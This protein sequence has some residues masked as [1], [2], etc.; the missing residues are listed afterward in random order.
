M[1]KRFPEAMPRRLPYGL[2]LACYHDIFFKKRPSGQTPFQKDQMSDLDK[3]TPGAPPKAPP[4]AEDEPIIDLVDEI[5]EPAPE[6]L[7]PL[8]QNLFGIT[9][10]VPSAEPPSSELAD[11]GELHFDEEEHQPIEAGLSLESLPGESDATSLKENLDWLF[12][13]GGSEEAPS[14][15]GDGPSDDASAAVLKE[16]AVGDPFPEAM[17]PDVAATEPLDEDEDI[18]LIEV[19]DDDTDTEIVW[20][21]DLDLDKAPAAAESTPEAPTAPAPPLDIEADLFEETSAADV[22]AANVASG[23][24]AG[25]SASALAPTPLEPPL[26]AED[27]PTLSDARID[28]AVERVIERRLG[29]TLESIVLR[30]VETAVSAEI[31]RL[32][33]LLLEDDPGDR[34]S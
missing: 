6:R 19:E 11:L 34:S 28:A 3:T 22:F 1:K 4:Q 5:E 18:E 24:A 12:E 26:P 20:F 13:P 30:A 21:D 17:T 2:I 33:S 8:E 27:A 29:G 14:E 32:K 9:A 15:A 16:P 10:I 31:Q 23:P 25:D 7:S